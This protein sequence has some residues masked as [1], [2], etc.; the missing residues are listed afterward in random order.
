MTPQKQINILV[1]EEQKRKIDQKIAECNA[2]IMKAGHNP[3]SKHDIFWVAIKKF[4]FGDLDWPD[5]LEWAKKRVL[6]NQ[7]MEDITQT[8][9]ETLK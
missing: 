3:I 6:I 1:T 4:V 5:S 2:Q 8:L 7:L 9:E